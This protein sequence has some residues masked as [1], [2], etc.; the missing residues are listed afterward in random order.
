MHV[1]MSKSHR[2]R[3]L[4][5]ALAIFSVSFVFSMHWGQLSGRHDDAEAEHQIC[6]TLPLLSIRYSAWL[7]VLVKHG[8]QV[9][10]HEGQI[11]ILISH[12]KFSLLFRICHHHG[13]ILR[14]Q[15]PSDLRFETL[16]RRGGIFD[17]NAQKS[18]TSSFHLV[19]E[20]GR[21]SDREAE[22]LSTF[23]VFIKNT[24]ISHFLCD[25]GNRKSSSSQGKCCKNWINK[26]IIRFR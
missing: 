11:Y 1:N 6:F 22:I 2:Q 17:P 20:K 9:P 3:E 5:S 7:F 18:G 26:H 14:L 4:S 25:R 24:L 16:H 19:S 21:T 12:F 23:S 10:V 8:E 13:V 15:R